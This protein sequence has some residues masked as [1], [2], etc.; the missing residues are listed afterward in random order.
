MAEI[1]AVVTIDLS[2]MKKAQA[3][4]DNPQHPVI[5]KVYK[6]WAARY[7]AFLRERYDRL[8]RGGGEWPPLSEATIRRRRGYQKALKKF[9]T[10]KTEIFSFKTSI[11]RDTNTMF[12][13]LQPTFKGAPGALEEDIEHGIR[14][15]YGGPQR[16]KD[17][18]AA[19]IADIASFHQEGAGKLPK[20]EII[21][22]PDNNTM[23]AMT[24][25]MDRGVAQMLKDTG[26]Q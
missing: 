16:Y 11:L 7:R 24:R 5:R 1:A 14:V 6:Q 26:N 3:A 13:A 17:G 25:D 15:G 9:L 19:T 21:V 18:G 8:S 20:R 12:T 10:G 2:P 22:P 4:L 23:E